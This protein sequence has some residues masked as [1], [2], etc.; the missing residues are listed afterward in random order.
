M[1]KQV[2]TLTRS[3]WQKKAMTVSDITLQDVKVLSMILG[4][5]MNHSSRIDCVNGRLILMAY[6]M[7]KDN[8]NYNV[9]EVLRVHLLE[10]LKQIK[11]A[12]GK[13]F[14][15]GSLIL[16]LFFHITHKFPRLN[17]W[18]NKPTMTQIY[19]HYLSQQDIFDFEISGMFKVFQMEMK[20]RHRIPSEIVKKYE[21]DICFMVG[22]D[23]TCF[24]AVDPRTKWCLPMGYEVVADILTNM[25]EHV[26]AAPIDPSEERWG[27]YADKSSQ[28]H[29]ILHM[30]EKKRK[31]EKSLKRVQPKLDYLRITSMEGEEVRKVRDQ[32]YCT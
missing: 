22:T 9:C 13:T 12:K 14:R 21:K 15:F 5:R 23:T 20:A 11:Q 28:V 10:N 25:V 32:Q 24:E 4:Y 31:V 6:K 18:T 27:T 7:A 1:K 16:Y 19:S 3:K 26:L 29:D 2:E 8:M 30:A 17:F